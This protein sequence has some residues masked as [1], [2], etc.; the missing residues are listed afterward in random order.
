MAQSALEA[1]LIDRMMI[2]V[3]PLLFGGDDAPGIFRGRGVREIVDALRLR[4][5]RVRPCGNDVIIEGDLER[6]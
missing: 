6:V 1:G 5:L 4:A 3:A 2:V